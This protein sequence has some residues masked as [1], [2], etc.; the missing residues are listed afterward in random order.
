[1]AVSL[2]TLAPWANLRMRCSPIEGHIWFA[3]ALALA[4]VILACIAIWT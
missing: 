1:M 3:I 4:V 2:L